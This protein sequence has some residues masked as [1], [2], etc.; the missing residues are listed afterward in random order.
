M[1]LSPTRVRWL[2]IGLAATTAAAV[3]PLVITSAPDASQTAGWQQVHVHR[4]PSDR[5]ATAF[6][7][8][9]SRHELIV[10]GGLCPKGHDCDTTW[11]W[12]G[13]GWH[14]IRSA[15]NPPDVDSASMAFDA[16][17]RQLVLFGG[18][19]PHGANGET[20]ILGRD[21]WGRVHPTES[22][23]PRFGAAMAYDARSNQLLLVDGCPD[24]VSGREPP[25]FRDT[26]DWTGV[27]WIQ[28]HPRHQPPSVVS[29]AMAYDPPTGQVVLFGGTLRSQA[30][31]SETWCW[32]GTD[33]RQVRVAATPPPRDSTSMAYDPQ[34][35][36]LVVFGGQGFL[37]VLNDTWAYAGGIWR[38]VAAIRHP[39]NRASAVLA[40]VPDDHGLLLFGGSWANANGSRTVALGGTWLL[41]GRLGLAQLKP[42][43]VS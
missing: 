15:V 9:P 29:A 31:S 2:L 36:G 3:I 11:A 26:W 27:S 30:D 24:L 25:C 4:S 23:P 33:W 21:G 10:F 32:Q 19:G 42:P 34:I 28:L 17:T 43:T 16:K 8:D 38:R 18:D 6:A 20:W 14:R 39:T 12:N 5:F 35:R 37:F 1:A 22:P 13:V 41:R 40:Y 7:F